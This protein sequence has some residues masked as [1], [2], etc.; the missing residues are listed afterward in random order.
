MTPQ[1]AS[2]ILHVDV[3][4]IRRYIY[5]GKL[6]A[7]KEHVVISGVCNTFVWNISLNSIKGFI[8]PRRGR[9]KNG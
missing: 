9:P 5:E 7:A 3:S 8:K 1:E 2:V 6:E 4:T